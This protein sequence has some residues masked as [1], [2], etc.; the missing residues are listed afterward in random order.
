MDCPWRTIYIC[1][2][3]TTKGSTNCFAGAADSNGVTLQR[4]EISVPRSPAV[5]RLDSLMRVRSPSMSTGIGFRATPRTTKIISAASP[6]ASA[7]EVMPTPCTPGCFINFAY[8]CGLHG[9][10]ARHF[11]M[12]EALNRE[13]IEGRRYARRSFHVEDTMRASACGLHDARR[14]AFQLVGERR[15]NL[16]GIDDEHDGRFPGMVDACADADGL[17]VRI[18]QQFRRVEIPRALGLRQLRLGDAQSG[19]H[20]FDDVRSNLAADNLVRRGSSHK[21][22][23]ITLRVLQRV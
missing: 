19:G 5:N 11:L 3:E 6:G 10:G 17:D 15:R 9:L 2:I 1:S 18:G 20:R 22:R 14:D 8:M 16:T 13:S 7:L 4:L 12:R 23:K 21:I